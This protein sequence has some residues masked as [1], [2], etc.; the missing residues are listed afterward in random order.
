M[1]GWC[2]MDGPEKRLLLGGGLKNNI[3]YAHKGNF[4]GIIEM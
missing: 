4:V 1:N 2:L 3:A